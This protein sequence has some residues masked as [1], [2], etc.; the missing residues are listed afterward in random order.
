MKIEH[1]L[2]APKD[3]AA[4]SRSIGR[5]LDRAAAETAR[6]M[7]RAAPKAHSTLWTSIR[8]WREGEYER[9][10]APSVNYAAAVEQGTGQAA[11]K[12]RYFPNVVHLYAWVKLR[13]RITFSGRQGSSLRRKQQDEVRDR[14]FALARYIAEHGTKPHPFVKPTAEKMRPRI[15]EL[16]AGG[17]REGLNR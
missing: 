13:A 10:V 3:P 5:F 9:M 17:V 14:A 16:L 8:A 1:T 15:L 2:P 12:K 4:F 7:Q 6:E 11:G